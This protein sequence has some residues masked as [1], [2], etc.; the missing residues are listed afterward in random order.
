MVFVS[1]STRV[2]ANVEAFNA[3][4]TVGNLTKHRRAPMIIP[5]GN[6]Y[7][8]VYV[9]AVSG[10][11]IAN[12]YQRALVDLSNIIYK[13]LG[14][15]PPLTEW[16]MRYEFSKYMDDNHLTQTLNNLV[17]KFSE[18]RKRELAKVIETKHLFEKTAISESIVADIGG[19]LYTGERL[20]VK[21][22]SRIYT[23]YMLPTYDSIDI[24]A[25]EAQL[26]ARH[27]PSETTGGRE[28]EAS[29]EA[30]RRAAQMI[31]YVE[32]A[33]A[34][35]GLSISIDLDG[36]GRTSLVKIEDAVDK[37][38][39]ILRVKISLTALETMF[40]GTGFG[41]KLARFTP[42]KRIVSAVAAVSHPLNFVVSPAQVKEYI[43]D[44]LE[45]SLSYKKISTSLGID[46]D[47]KIIVYGETVKK[48]EDFIKEKIEVIETKTPEEFFYRLTE[49]SLEV[50]E[51]IYGK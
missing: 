46:P 24:T 45:R 5:T 4:E 22:T 47:L 28:T 23:G 35:Y 11:S 34:L 51:K 42:I 13:K 26:H 16:D 9:P 36:I 32:V 33:S 31:Y 40:L 48:R 8:L 17:A 10:E 3:V 7:R 18:E 39:R 19:F 38:E 14:R 1:L 21:R 27:M 41:A 37:N 2:E 44:T 25:I 43:D 30:E 15:K 49:K 6:G 29:S 50:Y 12:A 20:P